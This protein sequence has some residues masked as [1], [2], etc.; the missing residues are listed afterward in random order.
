MSH[1][2]AIQNLYIYVADCFVCWYIAIKETRGSTAK[3]EKENQRNILYSARRQCIII[4]IPNQDA[5]EI[6]LAQLCILFFIAQWPA[7]AD[8]ERL[9]FSLGIIYLRCHIQIMFV[10]R[11]DVLAPFHFWLIQGTFECWCFGESDH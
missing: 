4:I 8:A 3:R 5:I 10:L 7:A 9:R 11:V 6:I 2:A 1:P